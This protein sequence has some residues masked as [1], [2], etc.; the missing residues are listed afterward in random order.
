VTEPNP[1]A[2][3]YDGLDPGAREALR[4]L[5]AFVESDIVPVARALDAADEYPEA[6][7]DG[8]RELGVFGFTIPRELGGQGHGL[9][10]YCL[11]VEEI[12]RGWMSVAGILNTHFI[13][14]SML[15]RFGTEEQR[16]RFLP[17]LATGEL[18][19]AFSMTEPHCG[20]DVQAIRTQAVRDGDE[21]VV[22]GEKRWQANGLRAGLMALLVKTDPDA[23]PPH[24]GMTCLLLEKTPGAMR[25]GGMEILGLLPKLGYLGID[26]TAMRLDGHRMPAAAVLGGE[27]G[28]GRGFQQMMSGVE[29]G[30]VNVAARAIGTARRAYE[31]AMSYA[32]EREA[33]GQ[34]LVEL[35]AIQ[36]KLADMATRIEAARLLAVQAARAK[37]A[38]HRADVET[39]MAK[40]FASEMCNEVVLDAMRIHGGNGYSKEYEIER[41]Y[42]DAPMLLLGEGTS[43]IQRTIV[44]RGLTRRWKERDGT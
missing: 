42:R 9:H 36:F 16:A 38:G 14:S 41:L 26:S 22:T 35:Q 19:A 5:R 30:R 17:R 40:L 32:N 21:W 37:D 23:D 44:A 8:L 29:V 34:Q 28:V 18:R 15:L 1:G 7:V 12:A 13:V 2:L 3:A 27:G 33:F 6:I 4:T 11:A 43:E 31:L 20:S 24:R 10:A 25:E 39:G